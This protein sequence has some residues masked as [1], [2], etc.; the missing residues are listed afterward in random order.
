MAKTFIQYVDPTKAWYQ[1]VN[2]RYW[3]KH[4]M[5]PKSKIV[6]KPK[7]P[8]FCNQCATKIEKDVD[9]S[10]TKYEKD[11]RVSFHFALKDSM[12]KLSGLVSSYSNNHLISIKIPGK[13]LL[14]TVPECTVTK[15]GASEPPLKFKKDPSHPPACHC[16]ERGYPNHSL[17]CIKLSE[18][19]RIFRTF[20]KPSPNLSLSLIPKP[21]PN[22]SFSLTVS[23]SIPASTL[24][25]FSDIQSE[26]EI[27]SDAGHF[28]RIDDWVEAT[29]NE[30]V[31][32]VPMQKEDSPGQTTEDP[33]TK[34]LATNLQTSLPAINLMKAVSFPRIQHCQTKYSKSP[35]HFPPNYRLN[36]SKSRKSCSSTNCYC[37]GYYHPAVRKKYL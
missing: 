20:S 15:E 11:E 13:K 19:P 9:H 8:T 25:T 36:Y 30:E 2:S 28:D 21:S 1:E 26:F 5:I 17:S 14:I 4:S 37:E 22:L 32:E 18:Q 31:E 33:Q 12:D 6:Q 35:K 23:M 24:P 34:L 29:L 16:F 3:K 27:G 10:R 7:L